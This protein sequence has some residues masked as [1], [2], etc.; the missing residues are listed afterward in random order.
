MNL[1]DAIKHCNGI[2]EGEEQ[3]YK[4]WKGD[5]SHLWKIDSC[6]ECAKEYRQLSDWLK[7]LKHL[8]LVVEYAKKYKC[9]VEHAEML[10]KATEKEINADGDR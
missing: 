6:L 8:R 1:E 9:P 5:Y 2:A 4:D 7:E 3:K 10:I